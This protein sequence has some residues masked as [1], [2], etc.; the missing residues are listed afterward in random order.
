MYNYRLR[1]EGAISVAQL[2]KTTKASQEIKDTSPFR[3]KI[4]YHIKVMLKSK[5]KNL[6]LIHE[7]SS[8]NTFYY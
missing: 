6:Q 8:E 4:L 2:Q 3:G 1:L 7:I 5:F